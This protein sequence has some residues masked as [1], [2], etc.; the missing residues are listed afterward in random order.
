M[1]TLVVFVAV[2]CTAVAKSETLSLSGADWRIHEDVDGK[3]ADRGIF[4]T[5][6]SSPGWIAA[7]VPGNIQSDLET[8][9]R[10][11]P[12]WYGAGDPKLPDVARKDWWYCKDFQVPAAFHDKR[13]TLVFDGVDCDCEVWLNGQLIG[14]RAG[15][16]RRIELDATMAAKPG[17]VNRLAVRIAKMPDELAPLVV[18]T[19]GPMS[20]G[21]VE[22][23]IATHKVLKELKSPTNFGWDWGVNI[24]TIGIWKDVRL[25]ATGPAR[26][27]WTGVRTDLSDNF[28]K[29]TVWVNLEI[30]SQKE[31]NARVSY[32]ITG[33][34]KQEAAAGQLQ[35]TL[36]VTLKQGM[37]HVE[38]ELPLEHPALWWCNGQGNQPLYTLR[39]AIHPAD[40]GAA[41]DE[42]TTRFGVR[43]VQ[44]VHTQGAPKDFFS[45]YQLILNGR[46]VRTMGSCLIPPDLL[47]GRCGPKSL[48]LLDRARDAGM[49]MLRIWGGGVILPDEFYARADELGIMLSQEMPL[50]NSWPETDAVF[51]ANLETTARNIIKQL[52]NHPSVIEWDGGNEM[53][54]N[55]L[56][57]HPA[58]QVLQ[59]VAGEEDNR[60]MRATCPD[61][62][63][64]H[65]PWDFDVPVSYAHYNHARPMRYGEF[66][67]QT[68]AN[69]EVWQREVP[70]KSQWPIAVND[71]ILI[72][73]NV[74]QAVFS[75]EHWL[76]KS[77]IEKLFGSLDNLPDVVRGGQFLGAE[78]LRYACDSNRRAGASMGGFTT[79]D[80]NEPWP[81]G[82]GSFMVDYDG[83]TLMNYDFFKQA[84]A[85]IALTL[86]YDSLFYEP[87]AGV[88]TELFLVSDAPRLA[89]NLHWKWLARD[90]RG[91]VFA[92][93]E[94]TTLISPLEVKSLG[95]ILLQ[96]PPKTAFGPM[97]L[98]LR[99]E[100][101]AD[102]LFTERLHVFGLT[103]V[104]D[105]LRGLLDNQYADAD[106]D[107]PNTTTP[108]DLPNGPDNLA[109]VGNGAKTATASSSRPEPRHQP[110]GL[111]DGRYGNNSSWIGAAPLSWFQIDLGKTA[112]VGRFKLGRDRTGGFSDRG[113]DY[114]KI[115]VSLDGQTWKTVVEQSAVASL[116]G[117]GGSKAMT[118][119]ITPVETRFVRATVNS[120]DPARG[121][122]A[123]I[124]EFEVYA[125]LNP[126]PLA[127]PR[128]DILSGGPEIRRPVYRTTLRVTPAPL[129]R[130]G[131]Q[132]VLELAV[133]NNGTMTA[134]FCEPHPQLVYR[135]DLFI[136]N[137]NCYIPPGE[138]RTFT[139]RAPYQSQCGLKLAQTGWRVSCWNADDAVVSPTSDVLL[140][141]G[142][143]D[144]TSKAFPGKNPVLAGGDVARFEFTGRGTGKARLRIHTAD[145]SPEPAIVEVSINGRSM[146]KPLP[147]GMGIQRE[148]PDH[149]AFPATLEFD[150]RGTDLKAGRNTLSVR[151]KNSGW[152]SW[153][154]LDLVNTKE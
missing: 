56:T 4:Q 144:K 5:D 115:E 40:G 27:A 64:E 95:T 70:P 42:R 14:R 146:E 89:E 103:G 2:F 109:F 9:H 39:A 73:K 142:R 48:Q 50:A 129:R 69:L 132:E 60:L 151:I 77:R 106:D 87:N 140:W 107:V 113:T 118:V 31:G 123:C 100:D 54:W 20:N 30:D 61:L 141:A 138:T 149:L 105:P 71:P 8:A 68:P 119:S 59:K 147:R 3:G 29:A 65:S 32:S 51:L 24:W 116:P 150:L 152:F 35:K 121:E 28:R 53:P 19:D 134:L 84:I 83:R 94:G 62:G 99:L 34:G 82:A 75:G 135:T 26:I 49:T 93:N 81:N 17:E 153:D 139:I 148:E 16:F 10:L 137:N 126:P 22:A 13:L 127:T 143:R 120:K 25:E 55:S 21:F 125:P 80:F 145:Q 52:R 111:N 102:K 44:W 88:K 38:A 72:R 37:N 154:A 76:L 7:T 90:R 86:K 128:V 136:D 92:H 45:R 41:F 85:P 58:L 117:Y 74:V 130:E 18:R 47:F 11:K 98:E 122:L 33:P 110:P 43:E 6:I 66:G 133:R 114:L 131:E 46:P 12:L 1:R 96:P 108:V 97:F 104:A 124:D 57:K 15:M 78:G 91:Q 63:A 112:I 101:A 79:W 67:A 23:I 36:D